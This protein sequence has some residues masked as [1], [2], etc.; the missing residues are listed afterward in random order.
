MN[1][2]AII[3][4]RMGSTRLP[5]KVL[6]DLCGKPV[7]QHVIDALDSAKGID[8]IV[9]ATTT[10]PRDDEIEEF[11]EGVPCFRGSEDDVL[12]RMAGAAKVYNADT[13]IRVTADCPFIDPQVVSDLIALQDFTGADYASNVN[14][15][16]YPDGL[17]CEVFTTKALNTANERATRPSDRECV[18]QYIMR[19][20]NSFRIENLTCPL[21][22]LHK[23]R[24][25]LDTAEDYEFCKKIANEIKPAATYTEILA[26]LRCNPDWRK[27]NAAPRNERFYD[28]ISIEPV[29]R[30]FKKSKLWLKKT[31]DLI[32]LGTQ[33]FSK[34]R[35]QYPPNA[36]PLFVSHGD[37]GYVYDI[38]GNDYVDLVGGLLPVILGYRD[39]DVDRAIRSQLDAGIS[40][41][42][43]S[44]L[45]YQLAQTLCRLIPCAEMVRFGKNGSDV[46][47]AAIRLSR[48]H[49][50]RDHVILTGYHGWHDWAIGWDYKRAGGVPAVTRKLSHKV[51]FGRIETIESLLK[52]RNVA[53]VIIEP[54]GSG[55]NDDDFL[56]DL[57][58][59]CT[60]HEAV[61]IFDEVITGF[62]W[63]LGG[64][65]ARCGVI[66][67]LATFGKSMGNGMPISAIVGKKEIM[68][69][70]ER[71]CYSGTF[72]GET[73][74]IAAAIAT[75]AKI[76]ALETERP[77]YLWTIGTNLK[78]EIADRISGHDLGNAITLYGDPILS[79]LAFT[80][81]KIKTLFLKEMIASGT[82]M[83][84]S[85]NLMYSH[86]Q[87]EL[88]RVLTS[89]DRALTTVAA[90]I[91]DI[92]HIVPES[93]PANVSVR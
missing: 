76:E 3:L 93:I 33:T 59:L 91:S 43:A 85:H 13:V 5:G 79:R 4:A 18:T 44:D 81:D 2:V 14:P 17:D 30:T 42:L 65:Q 50:G 48:Y 6:M 57:R 41:S 73:L 35:L 89:Y 74:S 24:W 9:V 23:E 51:D 62:R 60:E 80:S 26:V 1:T 27:I 19:N 11:C 8:T 83:I 92:D 37:R 12:S 56:V 71:V 7:L 87:P 84:A 70:M 36:A 86:G 69:Y 61:L 72:F 90:S 34:S 21:P 49:T 58:E 78:K 55:H 29:D 54:D 16:T 53:A 63:G 39:P 88:K 47:T 10:D 45:E 22:G 38:D 82:L 15:P 40:L 64:Y 68:K 77:G 28:N 52:E 31:N 20:R 66:P 25:V 67:D 75:I 32:P 46:T